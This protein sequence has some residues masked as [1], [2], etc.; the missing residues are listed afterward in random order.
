MEV[1]RNSYVVEFNCSS[2]RNALLRVL[3]NLTN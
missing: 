1:R 2:P 3:Q